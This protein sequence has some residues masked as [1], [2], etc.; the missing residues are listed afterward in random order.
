MY[1]PYPAPLLDGIKCYCTLSSKCGP[2]SCLS[3]FVSG[4]HRDVSFV[5]VISESLP[6]LLDFF[7][8][9]VASNYTV[10]VVVI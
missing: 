1:S 4:N 3:H 6:G 2:S 7:D 5:K 10:F 8:D 9:V